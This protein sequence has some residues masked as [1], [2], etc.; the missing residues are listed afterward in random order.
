MLSQIMYN[1][2]LVHLS[3]KINRSEASVEYGGE[4]ES[5]V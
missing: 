1:R 2:N 3:R 4:I 5:Q